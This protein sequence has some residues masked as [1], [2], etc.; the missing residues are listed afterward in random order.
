MFNEEKYCEKNGKFA[1]THRLTAER[2]KKALPVIW[3]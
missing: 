3:K 1:S 2:I